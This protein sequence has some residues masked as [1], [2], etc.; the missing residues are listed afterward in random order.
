MN[1]NNEKNFGVLRKDIASNDFEKEKK[2]TEEEILDSNN[3][4]LLAKYAKENRRKA[5]ID[6]VRELLESARKTGEEVV[7]NFKNSFKECEREEKD[8]LYFENTESGK[9]ALSLLEKMPEPFRTRANERL[10]EYKQELKYNTELSKKY[11]NNPVALWKE[12]TGFDYRTDS[13]FKERFKA[14]LFKDVKALSEDYWANNKLKVDIN[15]FAVEFLI[16]DTDSYNKLFSGTDNGA[17]VDTAG[18]LK[19]SD[20]TSS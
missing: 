16:R 7:Q 14:F 9:L 6:K 17:S 3:V 5:A 2:L 20:K 18:F 12:I 1:F 4:E 8:Y 13:D 19:S 11:N 15:P 10:I